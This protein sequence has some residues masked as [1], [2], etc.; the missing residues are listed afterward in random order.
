M[1]VGTDFWESASGSQVLGLQQALR[2]PQAQL[3]LEVRLAQ[4]K[5]ILRCWAAMEEGVGLVFF[6]V[7]G[8]VYVLGNI[9]E[10]CL[11]SLLCLNRIQ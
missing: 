9:G 4:A 11:N 3:T 2:H 1:F 10:L 6:D 8:W 5:L 7:I